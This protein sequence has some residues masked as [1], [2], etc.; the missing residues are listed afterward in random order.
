[1]EWSLVYD[2]F[3]QHTGVSYDFSEDFESISGTAAFDSTVFWNTSIQCIMS[4]LEDALDAIDEFSDEL[5]EDLPD[6]DDFKREF[7]INCVTNVVRNI[8]N[9]KRLMGITIGKI[10]D[11]DNLLS[12]TNALKDLIIILKENSI[13]DIMKKDMF[14]KYNESHDDILTD[15]FELHPED[16]PSLWDTVNSIITSDDDDE[17]DDL[18]DN[19]DE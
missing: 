6:R 11:V 5:I 14:N 15:T 19:E 13:D 16:I 2:W 9:V 12:Q 1:M 10:S 7:T 4:D 3:T 8:D 18:T 17:A